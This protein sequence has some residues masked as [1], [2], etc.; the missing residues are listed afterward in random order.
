[1]N[2]RPFVCTLLLCVA[3]HAQ[4]G[5]KQRIDAVLE[6]AVRRGDVAGVVAMTADADRILYHA[7]F[8]KR[9]VQQGVAMTEDTIFRIFSMTKPLASVAA[10]QLVERG[11]LKLDDAVGKYLPGVQNAQV[12]V[13]GQLRAPHRPVTVRH[14]LTHTSGY[15]HP[16][17]NATLRKYQEAHP[18][19]RGEKEPLLFDPGDHWEYGSS[20]TVLGQLVEHVA[21]VKLDEYF[22]VHI[23]EPLAMHHT[24]FNVPAA[25]VARMASMHARQADGSLKETPR[26]APAVVTSFNAASGLYGTAGDYV[27]FMQMLLQGGKASQGQVL[28]ARTIDMMAMNQIGNL[29]A[30]KMKTAAQSASQ[31]VDFHPGQRDGFGLG[32]LINPVAYEGGRARGSL[33]WAGAANTFFWVDRERKICAVLMMQVLPFFDE[34]A[35]G[36]LRAFEQAVY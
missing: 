5:M 8:G 33:A 12:L 13:G 1:M 34:R 28:A 30:G 6:S 4:Q 21:G 36:L 2:L 27:S 22:R 32:F 9:D 11:Q 17:W 14:L 25:S 35:V 7:A 15:A 29:A 24:F 26:T 20:T 18:E 23:L 31:D 10:M 16:I 3:A 19:A